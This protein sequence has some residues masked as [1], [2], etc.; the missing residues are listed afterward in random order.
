MGGAAPLPARTLSELLVSTRPSS[1]QHL[2]STQ[3]EM[4]IH[5]PMVAMS[6]DE[7]NVEPATKS[8]TPAYDFS[9][10][11]LLK[12]PDTETCS[13]SSSSSTSS[14]PEVD[15]VNSTTPPPPSSC[16]EIVRPT[17]LRERELE[18]LRRTS[19]TSIPQPHPAHHSRPW[20]YGAAHKEFLGDESASP[21]IY[22]ASTYSDAELAAMLSRTGGSHIN[23]FYLPK[24]NQYLY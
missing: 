1:K 23:I 19:A 3:K 6:N 5:R 20:I 17:P 11:A 2:T 4:T 18:F 13:S 24:I 12:Q 7:H 21:G 16:S 14:E 8:P 10:R 22:A 9:V 15:V